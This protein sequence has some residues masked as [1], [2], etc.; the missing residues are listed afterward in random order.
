MTGS[1]ADA[2][3]LRAYPTADGSFSLES[4]RFGE[5]FHSSSGALN[6]ARAKFSR[7]AELDR[8]HSDDRLR[9]LDVCVGL[10][11]NTAVVLAALAENAPALLPL[12]PP[13]RSQ[14]P[15]VWRASP[16]ASAYR[17]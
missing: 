15:G 9:I 6:E 1:A 12:R 11:Y 17:L 13:S 14:Q 4:E 16:I 10:G 2:D 7:P 5:A 8:W 3:G